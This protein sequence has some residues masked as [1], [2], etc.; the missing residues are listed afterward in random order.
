MKWECLQ[1]LSDMRKGRG[2]K[3]KGVYGF[4]NQGYVTFSNEK[5]SLN[6]KLK[7]GRF[8]INHGFGQ[9]SKIFISNYSRP[10]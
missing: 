2:K 4:S 3:S 1:A 5:N 7:F 8:Y 9:S 6:N 10:F